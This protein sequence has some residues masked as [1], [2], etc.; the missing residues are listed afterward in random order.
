MCTCVRECVYI[1]YYHY[2]L[3]DEDVASFD[4]TKTLRSETQTYYQVLIDQRDFPYIVNIVKCIKHW[5]TFML[6]TEDAARGSNI[7]GRQERCLI[8]FNTRC[9]YKME[10]L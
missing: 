4:K 10:S 6:S 3:K 8:V 9:V 7:F 1:V 2:S 5:N